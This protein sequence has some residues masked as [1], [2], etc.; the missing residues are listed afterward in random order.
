VSFWEYPQDKLYKVSVSMSDSAIDREALVDLCQT[1]LSTLALTCLPDSKLKAL[2]G[3]ER[4][5]MNDF[6]VLIADC[7]WKEFREF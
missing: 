3:I 5:S 4:H 6:D 1:G 7:W 2:D